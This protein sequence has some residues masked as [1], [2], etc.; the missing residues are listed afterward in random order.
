M[1]KIIRSK[2]NQIDLY[3]V[4][5]ILIL[6]A[7]GTAIVFSAGMPYAEARYDDALYFV[8]R[9]LV[10]I[11]IG[12]STM[13]LSSLIPAVIYKKVSILIY[14]STILLLILVLIVGF[15]LP[16]FHRIALVIPFLLPALA[17]H[18]MRLLGLYKSTEE[19]GEQA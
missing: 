13:I 10:W 12:I 1:I 6:S 8:K 3:L 4:I 5:L 17:I 19:G 16:W 9:Q 15:V 11:T 2:N 18:A 14:S 7:F